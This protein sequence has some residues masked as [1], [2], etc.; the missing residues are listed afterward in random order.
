MSLNVKVKG[1]RSRS[2]GTKNALCTPNTPA[3]LT[4]WN[5][6]V[7]D[8]VA[9]VA[10]ASS[11]LLVKGAFAGLRS[12]CGVRWAW[13]ATA[14]LCHAFLVN[15]GISVLS[16]VRALG[17]ANYLTVK[18]MTPLNFTTLNSASCPLLI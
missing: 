15:F 9:Q 10:N 6:L 4:E 5:A 7:A 2:S 1:Q 17:T 13:R 12:A 3:V 8:N 16:F 18:Q 11:P 14:G